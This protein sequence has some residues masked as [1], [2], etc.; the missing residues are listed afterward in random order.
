MSYLCGCILNHS[1]PLKHFS[2]K[3]SLCYNKLWDDPKNRDIS[4]EEEQNEKSKEFS[5]SLERSS[6]LDYSNKRSKKRDDLNLTRIM[7]NKV[8]YNESYKSSYYRNINLNFKKEVNINQ[9]RRN[10]SYNKK[11]VSKFKK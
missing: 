1:N 2:N 7:I 6:E 9:N 10:R 8:S 4:L 5:D 11:F 3:Q